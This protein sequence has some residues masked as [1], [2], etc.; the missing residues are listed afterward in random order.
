MPSPRSAAPASRAR[1]GVWRR[2]RVLGFLGLLAST[3]SHAW[4]RPPLARVR[5]NPD[6]RRA[7]TLDQ[8]YYPARGTRGIELVPKDA[9]LQS[10]EDLLFKSTRGLGDSPVD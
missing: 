1:F 8:S 7:P 6:V 2:L 4:V 9:Y 5:R 10:V 3:V